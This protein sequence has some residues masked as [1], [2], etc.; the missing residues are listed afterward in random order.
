MIEVDFERIG[1]IF[2]ISELSL[3]KW[4]NIG[5]ACLENFGD[6]ARAVSQT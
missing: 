2:M 5:P 6:L 3:E 4:K 1:N